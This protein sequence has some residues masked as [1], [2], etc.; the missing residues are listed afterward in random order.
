MNTLT[1]IR[2]WHD[3][4]CI[5]GR[6]VLIDFKSYAEAKGVSYSPFCGFHI[7]VAD[8]EA[9]AA[10]QEVIFRPGDILIIRFGFTE[11]LASMTGEEQAAA[12]SGARCC[13]IEGS[14]DMAKW[15]WNQHFAAVA[16]DDVAVEAMPPIVDGEEKPPTHL[17]LHQWCLSLLGFPLGELWYLKRLTEKCNATGR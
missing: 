15:L 7:G 8:I 4:G 11:A 1:I 10:F 16:N 2:D 5:A 6:G 12:F 13:G 14:K 3:R 9:V 17:A